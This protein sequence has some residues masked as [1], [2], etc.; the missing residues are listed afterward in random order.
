MK[1]T[2]IEEIKKVCEKRRWD[3]YAYMNEVDIY[4]G[5]NGLFNQEVIHYDNAEGPKDMFIRENGASARFVRGEE[6]KVIP[7]ADADF[8]KLEADGWEYFDIVVEPEYRFV[9]E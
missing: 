7:L 9:G 3:F 4:I 5:N 6:E 1:I 2:N 8:D